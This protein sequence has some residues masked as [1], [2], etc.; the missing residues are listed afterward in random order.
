MP[1]YQAPFASL[2]FG[3]NINLTQLPCLFSSS[4]RGWL[5][6]VEGKESW[7]GKNQI[8]YSRGVVIFHK[9]LSLAL[10]PTFFVLSFLAYIHKFLPQTHLHVLPAF[11]APPFVCIFRLFLRSG[12]KTFQ[13]PNFVVSTIII[14]I[15]ILF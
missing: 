12:I 9:T 11:R 3:R 6:V 1:I 15:M 14:I 8:Y 4:G 10:F 7:L 2:T 5:L 13:L